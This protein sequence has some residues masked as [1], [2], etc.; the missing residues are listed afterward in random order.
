RRHA[1]IERLRE[2][3][4]EAELVDGAQV[5]RR[6]VE[7]HEALELRHPEAARLHVE[8]LPALGLDV[9]VRDVLRSNLVLAGEIAARHGGTLLS[10]VKGGGKLRGEAAS[11]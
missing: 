10:N 6:H 2:E 11:V 3:R 8:A 1:P 5:A 9:R 7:A 4:P